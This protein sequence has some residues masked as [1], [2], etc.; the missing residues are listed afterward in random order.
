MVEDGASLSYVMEFYRH[1]GFIELQGFGML[2]FIQVY[3]A[4]CPGVCF[5][6]LNLENAY[7]H[8]PVDP[9]Y[10]ERWLFFGPQSACLA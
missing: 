5:V 1:S 9:S 4:L 2:M 6:T 8:I 7:W 3:L 10:Q